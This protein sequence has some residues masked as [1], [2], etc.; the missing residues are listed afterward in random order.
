MNADLSDVRLYEEY[1]KAHEGTPLSFGRFTRLSRLLREL[2]VDPVAHMLVPSM[3]RRIYLASGLGFTDAGAAYREELHRA[4]EALGLDVVDPWDLAGPAVH[5]VDAGLR[6]AGGNFLAIAGCRF[7]LAILD[8]TDVDSG[9]ACECGF[10]FA[11]G[12]VI[13]GLRS[14]VRPV[15]DCAG[16]P[17][18]LQVAGS[19]L[20]S[21]GRILR[22][23]EDLGDVDWSMD[24][25]A[26]VTIA[27]E[28]ESS[29]L[30]S[31]APTSPLTYVRPRGAR[32]RAR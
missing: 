15:G 17:I 3:G 13:H 7:V 25:G 11:L 24:D 1:L 12:K 30:A 5:D 8:G 32:V 18:N 16:L 6:V 20:A 14:D 4:L 19:V 27:A 10:A 28:D 31:L 23:I 29:P 2:G 26:T 9:V 22:S 21:G